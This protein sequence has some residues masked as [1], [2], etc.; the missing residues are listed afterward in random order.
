M[1]ESQTIPRHDP[2]SDITLAG[3]EPFFQPFAAQ[4]PFL[5]A[6]DPNV[7]LWGDRGGGKSYLA[8]MFAHGKAMSH[9]GF[10]YIIIRRSYPELLKTHCFFLHEEMQRLGGE[11]NGLTYNKSEHICYYPKGSAGF[12]YQCDSDEDVRKVLGAEAALVIF[13]EAPELEFS[14]MAEIKASIRVPKASGF[15]PMARY[16]GNPFGPSIDDLWRYFIDKDVDP[17]EDE[18]YNPADWRAIKLVLADNPHLDPA[19]YRKQFS[20]I[21]NTA[22][23]RAWR[24]GERTID[25][26][27]FTLKPYHVIDTLPL[28]E[29]H[30]LIQGV[31]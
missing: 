29:G 10:K 7:F 16:L 24:D 4:L 26:A 28:F 8:R 11:K 31:Y 17:A 6:K 5:R 3:G 23:L 20:G 25:K 9:A 13:D 22:K 19:L 1:A 14:W 30:P 2:R 27:L 15:I 12:Y 21:Q 18:D